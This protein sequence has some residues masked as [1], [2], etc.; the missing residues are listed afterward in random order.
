MSEFDKWLAE[1]CPG[2]VAPGPLEAAFEAGQKA[3]Q[4]GLI[5]G[6]CCWC[7]KPVPPGT[8]GLDHGDLHCDECD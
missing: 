8:G 1:Y 7:E 2:D 4:E 3:G 5:R 6:L